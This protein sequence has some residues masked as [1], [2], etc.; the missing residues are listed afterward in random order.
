MRRKKRST[1]FIVTTL[2][3]LALLMAA[4]G[5]SAFSFAHSSATQ[6]DLNRQPTPY[7]TSTPGTSDTSTPGVMD[8]STPGATTTSTPGATDTSTP[9]VVPG[10][11][12]N[13]TGTP[14]ATAV[15]TYVGQIPEKNAWVGIDSNGNQAIAFVTD[16]TKSHPATF[17]NW[18]KGAVQNNKLNANAT[19]SNE[20]K[21]EA[22]LDSDK[23]SGT[24][25]MKDGKKVP[26]TANAIPASDTMSGLYRSE[27]DINGKKYI[28]GWILQPATATNPSATGTAMPSTPAS[29]TETPTATGTPSATGTATGT[30]STAGLQQAGAVVDEHSG[31]VMSV[32][33]LTQQD[34]TAKKVSIPKLGDFHLN[35]CQDKLC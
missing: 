30:P 9:G 22:T 34:I 35:Q 7:D 25:T 16:G 15:Q 10:A 17:A 26:F 13:A 14:G 28:A 21:L 27:R 20:G 18:Y 2:C 11:P 3:T 24:I 32:P 12:G 31:K 6:P 8:T 1:G 29:T 33:E 4:G 23:A 5:V 19:R